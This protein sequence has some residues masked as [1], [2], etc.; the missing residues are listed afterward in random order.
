[1]L[2]PGKMSEKLF[3][4]APFVPSSKIYIVVVGNEVLELND[5]SFSSQLLPA[6]QNL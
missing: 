1:M 2:F 3:N 6:M 5:T 4:V